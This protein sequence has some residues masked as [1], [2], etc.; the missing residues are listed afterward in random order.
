MKLS[1]RFFK[2]CFLWLCV[3]VAHASPLASPVG[4]WKTIDDVSGEAK[5]VVHIWD[6][7]HVLRGK[8]VKLFSEPNKR[9]EACQGEKHNQPIVGMMVMDH[10]VQDQRQAKEWINGTILDPKNGKTYKSILQVVDEGKKLNVRGYIGV[11]LFGRSQTW[12]R[13]TDA[14]AK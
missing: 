8:I 4:Y 12:L 10:F 2:I 5:S 7:D 11:P 13:V 3:Q 6:E 14:D 1:A 9:C